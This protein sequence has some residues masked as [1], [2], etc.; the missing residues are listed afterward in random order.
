GE[1]AR[2]RIR[3]D[4][5]IDG[6][7]DFP[8]LTKAE[9]DPGATLAI[10]APL[11][12]AN[13]YLVKGPVT[14]QQIHY[15]HGGGGSYV[16]LEGADTSIKMARQWKTTQ[17]SGQTDSDAVGHIIDSYPPLGKDISTTAAGHDE[18]KHTL[19]Q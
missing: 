17:F 8:L 5:D 14:G 10:I 1:T 3:Y 13:K 15:L 4:F 6:Q 2:Y 9:I 12:G 18:N 19:V 11:N 7:G 16:E